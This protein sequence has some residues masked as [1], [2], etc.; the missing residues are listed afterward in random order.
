MAKI[1]ISQFYPCSKVS[2]MAELYYICELG[3]YLKYKY[4]DVLSLDGVIISNDLKYSDK[5]EYFRLA[6][7]ENWVCDTSI[8]SADIKIDIVNP[9]VCDV[10]ISNKLFTQK[11]V[12]YNLEDSTKRQ[13]LEYNFRTPRLSKVVFTDSNDDFLLWDIN[14]KNHTGLNDNNL[15][16]NDKYVCY[17]I[18]SLIAYVAVKRLK[19][20]KPKH[21]VITL[22]STILLNN[23]ASSYMI[24]LV[25]ETNCLSGWFYY[26]FDKYISMD[27]QR[28][29]YYFAWY[30]QGLDKGYLKR[31]YTSKE[32]LN[33]LKELD[34]QEGDFVLW[35]ERDK[36]QSNNYIKTIKSCKVA[37]FNGIQNGDISLTYIN[38]TRP[39]YHQKREYD[40]N[41]MSVK[42]LYADNLHY[43]NI[44]TNNIKIDIN[45]CGVDYLM[46]AEYYFITSLDNA[47]DIIDCYVANDFGIDHILLDQ[48]NLLYWILEDYDVDYNKERFLKKY[49]SDKE[50][51]RD[52]YMRGEMLEEKYYYKED[53]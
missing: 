25:N 49:F 29:Y 16:V 18:V 31:F 43:K 8:N 36:K 37:R 34:I 40:D 44:R 19:S 15:S 24:I 22:G 50:P 38:T 46:F 41:S 45:E 20:G 13:S 17:N 23:F 39:K 28:Q 10:E 14:G 4:N 2:I 11:D 52:I 6:V 42:V 12:P 47:D 5:W 21:F 32:K 53:E 26:S 30:M 3:K 1:H 7:D 27:M 9:L 33:Y 51:L 35:Y 48:N